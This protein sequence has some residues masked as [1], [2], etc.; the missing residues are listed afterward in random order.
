MSE[1]KATVTILLSEYEAL[2]TFQEPA[3][4]YFAIQK[5]ISPFIE[6]PEVGPMT[7]VRDARRYEKFLNISNEKLREV[8]MGWFK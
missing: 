6:Y 7:F 4:R 5:E 1:F 3:E 8:V 2:R